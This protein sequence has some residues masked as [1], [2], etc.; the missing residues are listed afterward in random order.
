MKVILK[1]KNFRIILPAYCGIRTSAYI[2]M[3]LAGRFIRNGYPEKKGKGV[4]FVD[5]FS[6]LRY[7]LEFWTKLRPAL[8]AANPDKSENL[9][10]DVGQI[11]M[12]YFLFAFLGCSG[13]F[14]E[15]TTSF[16]QKSVL[17]T[18]FKS[19]DLW[20][21]NS[22]NLSWLLAAGMLLRFLLSRHFVI[23]FNLEIRNRPIKDE[24]AILIESGI[25]ALNMGTPALFESMKRIYSCLFHVYTEFVKWVWF[26]WLLILVGNL[27]IPKLRNV[28]IF[29]ENL[30]SK[31]VNYKVQNQNVFAYWWFV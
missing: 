3:V 29:H 12:L 8:E 6:S 19:E 9:D 1:N 31:E 28:L 17:E 22:K 4:R 26:Q 18:I 13:R 11:L 14:S 2:Y 24:T 15:S 25:Q 30:R 16:N 27:F 5:G 21:I 23:L 20:L 7:T 10:Q